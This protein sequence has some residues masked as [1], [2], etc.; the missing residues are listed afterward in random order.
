MTIFNKFNELKKQQDKQVEL[1]FGKGTELQQREKH[2]QTKQVN[3]RKPHSCVLNTSSVLPGTRLGLKCACE[4]L[5][6]TSSSCAQEWYAEEGKAGSGD[7]AG[8]SGWV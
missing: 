7:G 1:L 3:E 2:A 4:W 6:H 5:V 8:R